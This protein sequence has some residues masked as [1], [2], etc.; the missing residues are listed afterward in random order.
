MAKNHDNHQNTEQVADPRSLSY[1]TAGGDTLINT[2]TRQSATKKL[3]YRVKGRYISRRASS[4]SYGRRAQGIATEG[5][6]KPLR[7]KEKLGKLLRAFRRL[8]TCSPAQ[9][10]VDQEMALRRRRRRQRSPYHFEVFSIPSNQASS[11]GS[12]ASMQAESPPTGL[13]SNPPEQLHGLGISGPVTTHDEDAILPATDE[14]IGENPI[15]NCRVLHLFFDNTKDVLLDAN[16]NLSVA[17]EK[18]FPHGQFLS[19]TNIKEATR[20]VP[21]EGLSAIV[22]SGPETFTHYG[23]SKFANL[24][25]AL[26]DFAWDGG[27]LIIRG[28]KKEVNI[29]GLLTRLNINWEMM[30]LKQYEDRK[31][32]GSTSIVNSMRLL[33]SMSTTSHHL[34][35]VSTSTGFENS[36]PL[37]SAIRR[38]FLSM[39]P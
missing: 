21:R 9:N 10:E 34:K 7:V 3:Y 11:Q 38:H 18:E 14:Q 15:Q 12:P 24:L 6:T 8:C 13:N 17:H 37:S 30:P 33:R 36:V 29:G 4:A 23:G 20:Q 25:Q 1:A 5:K 39:Y 31:L 16:T 26:E 32:F 19:I 28:L 35:S 27:I 2:S 22:V